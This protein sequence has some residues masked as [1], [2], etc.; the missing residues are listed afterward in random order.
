MLL[1][2]DR[3][4]QA[5]EKDALLDE[6]VGA[7]DD[8][9]LPGGDAGQRLRAL[10]ALDGGGEEL[11]TVGAALQQP[12][13]GEEVLLGQDLGRSHEGRL[14]AVLQDDDHR[15][16]RHERLAR[17]HVALDQPVHGV[18]GPQV[19]R[20]LAQ[21]PP[22]RPG[23]GK[24]KDPLHRLAGGV[25]DLESGAPPLGAHADAAPGEADLEEEQLL[26][27]EPHVPRRAEGV[28]PLE[29]VGVAGQMHAPERLAAADDREPLA[30]VGGDRVGEVGGHLLREVR[31]DPP[32]RLDGERPELLVDGDEAAG[33][34]AAV[35]VPLDDLVL[36]RPH[37][38]EPRGHRVRLDEAE[39]HHLL[40]PRERLPQV[41]LVEE[42]GLQP[43]APV[44]EAHLVDRHAPRAAQARHRDLA[45][46][47]D[48]HA[49]AQVGHPRE[50]PP[51]LVAHGQVE[52]EV[53]GGAHAGLREGLGPLGAHALHVLDRRLEVH[54]PRGDLPT[55]G[56][57]PGSYWKKSTSA[58]PG[59]RRTRRAVKGSGNGDRM[60]KP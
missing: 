19:V 42:D 6:R 28:Q 7:D 3:E 12:P 32:Q 37:D 18:G 54:I 39:E 49:G 57:K 4:A 1:V 5:V 56:D 17:A 8:L 36:R 35:L 25:P 34:D 26:Q 33:V 2:D 50:A 45:R 48:A 21:H 16:K 24:G 52:Q 44:V 47:G 29:R 53:L 31:E 58:R 27:D 10:P 14:V 23:Q 9:R 51:V 41:G 46:D 22:L 15:E 60:S 40:A 30:H 43:P 20:D 13:Q 59:S 38:E 55:A 11:H